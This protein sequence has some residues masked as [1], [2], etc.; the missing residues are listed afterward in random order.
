VAG[1]PHAKHILP[2]ST[3]LCSFG[4]QRVFAAPVNNA[5]SSFPASL[6]SSRA[7]RESFLDFSLTSISHYC[8]LHHGDIVCFLSLIAAMKSFQLSAGTILSLLF[9]QALAN[10]SSWI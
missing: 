5:S 9:Y 1:L 2:S 10:I 6:L 3:S 7:A 8:T 4:I